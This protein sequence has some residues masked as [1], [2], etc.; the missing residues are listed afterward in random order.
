VGVLRRPPQRHCNPSALTGANSV[1]SFP[2]ALVFFALSTFSHSPSF[3]ASPRRLHFWDYHGRQEIQAT[4]PIHSLL[5]PTTISRF[6]PPT[7]PPHHLLSHPPIWTTMYIAPTVSCLD[8]GVH[9]TVNASS[10]HTFRRFSSPPPITVRQPI[11]AEPR[12][13][14]SSSS[15]SN[16]VTRRR[17]FIFNKPNQRNPLLQSLPAPVLP[18]L[19]GINPFASCPCS[20]CFIKGVD[21]GNVASTPRYLRGRWGSSHGV[22]TL[23]IYLA[24]LYERLI[25]D[26]L[27]VGKG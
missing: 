22:P 16:T 25:F 9:V 12:R 26:L 2:L 7:T 24:Q 3:T 17:R 18:S 23:G 10:C 21:R 19:V 1:S 5:R 20:F 13:T 8:A 14:M 15:S 4:T 6:S 27:A 11:V